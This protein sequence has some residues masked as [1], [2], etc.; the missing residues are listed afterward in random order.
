MLSLGRNVVPVVVVAQSDIRF[1]A[2]VELIR[3]VE[4]LED[5]ECLVVFLR[6]EILQG[7]PQS[8]RVS[9][10]ALWE[11]RHGNEA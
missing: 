4:S 5:E 7:T 2:C 1:V 9:L 6:L 8:L 10:L 3:L 11:D